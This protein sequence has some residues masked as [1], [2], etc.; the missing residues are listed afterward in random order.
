MTVSCNFRKEEHSK[1][2]LSVIYLKFP[3]EK[4]T[5][6]SGGGGGGTD[7]MNDQRNTKKV[8]FWGGGLRLNAICENCN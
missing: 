1:H 3:N 8:C 4:L 6:N 2:K 7:H 5:K